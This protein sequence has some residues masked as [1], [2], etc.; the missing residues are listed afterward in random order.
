M[1]ENSKKKYLVLSRWRLKMISF[2]L[3]H[4]EHIFQPGLPLSLPQVQHSVW[5]MISTITL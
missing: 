5:L 2:P 4:A 1:T 3:T